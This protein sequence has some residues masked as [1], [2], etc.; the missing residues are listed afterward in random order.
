MLLT[1]LTATLLAAEAFWNAKP[2]SDWSVEEVRQMMLRSPWSTVSTATSGAPIGVHLASAEPMQEAE[3]RQRQ[4]LRYRVELGASFEE[5][6]AMLK[7]GRYIVVAVLLRDPTAISDA[8]ESKS[9]E[10]DSVLH[11][12][13]RT[14]KLVTQFPPTAGDPYLRYVFP[15]QVK[16]TDKSLNFDLYIP[17]VVYPQRHIE[18][19]LREMIYK[20]RLAY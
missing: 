10:R 3:V 15:R 1:W 8:I 2:P 16:P 19:D 11:V 5:Y 6:A 17:G 7:E 4:A 20:G 12:G 9:L 14:Y 18:F 13:R